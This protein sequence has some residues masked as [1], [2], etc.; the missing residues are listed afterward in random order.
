M[1]ANRRGLIAALAVLL[2]ILAAL[3]TWAMARGAAEKPPLAM[4]TSLPIVWNEAASIADTLDSSQ[5][6]HWARGVVE[7][8]YRIDPLDT[9][10]TESLRGHNYLMLAQPRPLGPAENVALDNWVR[11]GGRLLLFADPFLTEHSRFAIG[12]R[13]RPQ[14]V[15]LLSPILRRWGLE[16]TFSEDQ[17]ETET[18]IDLWDESLPVRLSGALVA[19][20]SARCTSL[21]KA[22]VAQCRIGR[23]RV[24]VIADAALLESERDDRNAR[25]ALAAILGRAFSS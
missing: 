3:A 6:P 20:P 2:A 23:G 19:S 14:D 16:L 9:L 1:A 13:R 4:M 10:T 24:T 18:S 21:A 15:V 11:G 8:G 5:A 7:E 25:R 17:G 12:D 22:T